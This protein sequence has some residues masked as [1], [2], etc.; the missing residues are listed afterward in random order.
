MRRTYKAKL[1]GENTTLDGVS[2][3]VIFQERD[4]WNDENFGNNGPS[5][6]VKNISVFVRISEAQ[7][8]L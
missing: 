2:D 1:L 8:E 4:L 6:A 3:I 7:A 5:W